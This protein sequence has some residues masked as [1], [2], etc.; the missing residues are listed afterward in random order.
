MGRPKRHSGGYAIQHAEELFR[1]SVEAGKPDYNY[2]ALAI[3][4]FPGSPPLWAVM[5]CIE[6]RCD[7]EMRVA[8]GQANVSAVLDDVIRLLDR[9]QH[10][11][12]LQTGGDGPSDRPKYN[13]PS[14][15]STIIQVV[16]NHEKWTA[17]I[18]SANDDWMK[19]IRE[20]WDWE[21]K[22]DL[23]REVEGELL[24]GFETTSRINRVVMQS[25]AAER[26]DPEDI[27]K[28]AWVAKAMIEHQRG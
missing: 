19:P 10:K 13:P 1:Q 21:Q 2:V 16:K 20:A 15:R 6:H 22:H 5:E 17:C 8:R 9:L 14:L 27:A 28:W 11:F 3:G 4:S 7:V 12:W 26:G 18:D 23:S 24:D 25:V